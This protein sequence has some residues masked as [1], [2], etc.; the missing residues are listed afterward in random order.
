M[1]HRTH[2]H[3]NNSRSISNN[4]RQD[5]PAYEKMI[6]NNIEMVGKTFPKMYGNVC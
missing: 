5:E 3:N 1:Y 4:T 6:I 2:T